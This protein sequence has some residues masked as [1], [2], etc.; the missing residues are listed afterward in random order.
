M[1]YSQLTVDIDEADAVVLQQS[2]SKTKELISQVSFSLKK[3][4]ESSDRSVKLLTPIV[5]RNRQ[6]AVFKKNVDD[7]VLAVSNV[8]GI[9]SEAAFY[10][11]KLGAARIENVKQYI[12]TL[13]KS[14]EILD[15]LNENKDDGEFKGIRDNLRST[16]LDGELKMETLFRV[17][18]QPVSQSF[19]PQIYMSERRP[20]PYLEDSK[21]K[22]LGYIVDY[23]YGNGNPIDQLYIDNR[24]KTIRE[25]L[26][27]LVPFTEEI[28]KNPKVPYEKGTNGIGNYTEALLGF[29]SNE[30]SLLED[31]YKDPDTILRH[32][33]KIFEGCWNN[34]IQIVNKLLG[35]IQ[36][37]V[38]NEG[39]LAFELLDN[40]VNLQNTIRSQ[41][42]AEYPPLNTCIASCRELARS[43][44]KE[45][46]IFT[47]QRV[48][49]LTTLPQDNGVSEA[50]VEVM[51]KARK[52]ADFKEGA[53]SVMVGFK[54][55]SWIPQPKPQWLAKWTS[56]NATT[57]VD[58]DN[59]SELLS[60]FFSDVIDALIVSLEIKATQLMRKKSAIGY[61]LITNITLVEQISMR[62]GIQEI[63][64]STSLSRLERLKKRALEMFLAGWK[65]A[66][67]NLLDVNVVGKLSS[68][69]R[70]AIK[71]KFTNFNAEFEELVKGY[72]QYNIT[73]PSLKKYLT[74]EISFIVPLYHRF[75]DK[76]AGGDFTKH[77]EK[78]IKY[79][80]AEFDRIID[81]LGK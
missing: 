74:K 21:L 43:L 61:F 10:E 36:K 45:L 31:I 19:D 55:G 60:A 70:D 38:A 51:S 47:D 73:D 17:L 13:H 76:H 50:T 12:T 26:A 24:I 34:Y 27:F 65:Q 72:K 69:D 80:N 66:A 37:F 1:S 2:L 62:S 79:T 11:Q 71:Q 53:L 3:I 8:Q 41:T 7:S 25:S 81:S 57:V 46:L 30:W 39:L 59:P 67:A 52:F 14:E 42:G 40:S 16:V 44:F 6:L 56:I 18:L 68:K 63:L 75:H 58:D 78:Y 22:D 29:M 32:F 23:F 4:T 15:K 77:T 33:L 28:T 20:F 48:S 64:D 49:S 5:N 35:K 9:A 54:A